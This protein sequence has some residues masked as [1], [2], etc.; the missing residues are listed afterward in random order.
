MMADSPELR[1]DE[2]EYWRAAREFVRV[3][4]AEL[5][6]SLKESGVWK[7]RRRQICTRFAFGFASY[8]DQ[9]WMKVG[10][11]TRYPL[12]C[13]TSAFLDVDVALADLPPIL[14]PHK[15]VE[16][17]A[18]VSDEVDWYFRDMKEDGK[19]VITGAVG[20]ETE[21]SEEIPQ[22]TTRPVIPC[23][24]C[25]GTGKCFCLRKGSGDPVNCSRC[26]GSGQCRH[27]HGTG[28]RDESR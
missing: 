3:L 1:Q 15:S 12:L 20:E 14:C 18:M 22:Q 23:W 26:Q 10:G 28:R 4:I 13:F 27:C 24:T 17:H 19:A 7:A 5:N 9:Q 11:K 21:D 6:G 2:E 8:L 25:Q 16:L